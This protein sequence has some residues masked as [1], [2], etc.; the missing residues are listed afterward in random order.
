[1]LSHSSNAAA[2]RICTHTRAH[3]HTYTRTYIHAP[4]HALAIAPKQN[5][6]LAHTA[7]AAAAAAAAVTVTTAS[8]ASISSGLW[9][10]KVATRKPKAAKSSFKGGG[11]W[12]KNKYV[13]RGCGCVFLSKTF[14][15]LGSSDEYMYVR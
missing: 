5:A 1:M 12:I 9:E 11:C 3:T 8:K 14:M 15:F 6:K 7:A 2:E 10:V 13:S 4:T